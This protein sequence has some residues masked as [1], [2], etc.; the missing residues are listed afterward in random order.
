MGDISA[1][2]ESRAERAHGDDFRNDTPLAS[3]KHEIDANGDGVDQS[4][5]FSTLRITPEPPSSHTL[6]REHLSGANLAAGC[7]TSVQLTTTA[8]TALYGAQVRD[9][10]FRPVSVPPDSAVPPLSHDSTAVN[11]PVP[12]QV[13]HAS[14]TSAP[15]VQPSSIALFYH[16][17]PRCS[18]LC[19]SQYSNLFT[20]GQTLPACLPCQLHQLCR[21][22][23]RWL[24]NVAIRDHRK[25]LSSSLKHLANLRTQ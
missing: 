17:L 25:L 5:A 18:Q 10:P 11:V 22:G 1:L 16:S 3:P 21:W 19:T 14:T 20:P 9:S 24:S 12:M 7:A 23:L 8:S 13:P 2:L 6:G 4:G 15:G